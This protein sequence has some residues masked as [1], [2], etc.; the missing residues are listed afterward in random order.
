MDGIKSSKPFRPTTP[1]FVGAP[2]RGSER[3]GADCGHRHDGSVVDVGSGGE[4]RLFD[5]A[6]ARAASQEEA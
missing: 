1:V 4:R 5:A 2:W 6:T 3:A